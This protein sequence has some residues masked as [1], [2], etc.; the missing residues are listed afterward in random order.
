MSVC[1][2]LSEFDK[3]ENWLSRHQASQREKK[4]ALADGPGELMKL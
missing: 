3:L 4:P 1:R 2:L